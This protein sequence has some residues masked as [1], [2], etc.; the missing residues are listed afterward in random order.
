M[1]A[2][3]E[4]DFRVRSFV[5]SL[6]GL[7]VDSGAGTQGGEGETLLETMDGPLCSLLSLLFVVVA[8]LARS[9]VRGRAPQ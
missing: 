4:V 1:Y 5:S 7:G 2:Q 3:V 9:L 6:G 8:H